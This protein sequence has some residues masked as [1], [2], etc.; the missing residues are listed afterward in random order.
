MRLMVAGINVR[1]IACSASRAGHEVFAIDCYCDL[2]LQKCVSKTALLAT[3]NAEAELQALAD[4]F[5]P[6]AVVLGPGLEEAKVKGHKILNN[7]PQKVAQV[8]DK[9]WLARWLEKKGYPAIPT[10]ISWQGEGFPV[11]VKPRRGAGGAGC[12]IVWDEKDLG[13]DENMIIQD[14]IR[15]KPASASVI[16]N[17]NEARTI[18]VNEQLIGKSWVGAEGFRYC[19]NITPLLPDCPQIAR[20]AEDLVADLELIG[21]NGVDFLITKN[22]PIVVEVNPRFQGSLDTVELS[23]GKSV[24]QAHLEAFEGFLPGSLQP[25]II[26]GRAIFFARE[27]LYISQDL[28]GEEMTDIPRPG[29]SL[30]KDDPVLSLLATGSSRDEVLKKLKAKAAKLGKRLEIR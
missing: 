9:L 21:S 10:R 16:G 12:R 25:K 15:G 18:A 7:S 19:G 1:H 28:S 20:I 8:S 2:D 4:E 30:I 6:D 5:S 14:L 29:S 24:F 27:D 13:L 11:V 22:G 3:S 17:G 26:A 23:T